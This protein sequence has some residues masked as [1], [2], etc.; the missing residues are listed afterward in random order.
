M[1][2][3][4]Q[5]AR[6]TPEAD[7]I[8]MVHSYLDL[9][10]NHI[11]T[12]DVY[13]E[14]ASEEIVGK[15]LKGKRDGNI[16]ATKLRFPTGKHPNESGL[17][18]HHIIEG[19]NASLRRLDM[20]HVDLLYVHAWD[21]ITPI[22]ETM[23]ALDDLV[24]SG[25]VR[26]IGVSNFKAWQVMKAQGLADQLGYHRFIAGQYQYSLVK[27]DIEWEFIDLFE[28]EGI[29]LLPWGPLGGGFLTGKYKRNEKPIE[30]RISHTADH[31]EE[32]WE[33]RSTEQNWA[34][35]D[36]VE[37]LAKEKNASVSQVALAWVLHNPVVSSVIVGPRTLEQFD[38]NMGAAEISLSDV[39]LEELN[40]VSKPGELYPYRML[41]AYAGR[42]L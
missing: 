4:E 19:A 28:N 8:K 3:G 34:I 14:G 27:R 37:R 40:A 15:A 25:K 24:T 20:D 41:E 2:F 6:T 38:D 26:Y 33:R 30:G 42:S 5:S 21:P 32:S 11:D 16:V 7:A 39:E 23:R 13:A 9:G 29:G 1:L 17:S 22:Q 18:R 35:L 12:A 36:V 31:T 10:G